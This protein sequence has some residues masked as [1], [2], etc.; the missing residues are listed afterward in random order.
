MKNLIGKAKALFNNKKDNFN[1]F[2]LDTLVLNERY[3]FEYEADAIEQS[4]KN[5]TVRLTGNPDYKLTEILKKAGISMSGKIINNCYSITEDFEE[6][7]QNLIEDIEKYNIFS[8]YLFKDREGNYTSNGQSRSVIVYIGYTNY[9]K[10]GFIVVHFHPW[11]QIGQNMSLMSN[12]SIYNKEEGAKEKI[13]RCL[14][15]FDLNKSDWI[16]EKIK[17]DRVTASKKVEKNKELDYYEALSLN[18]LNGPGKYKEKGE[19][20]L[21]NNR[22]RDAIEYLTFTHKYLSE[23]ILKNYNERLGEHFLIICDR[24]GECYYNRGL[25]KMA[26]YYWEQAVYMIENDAKDEIKKKLDSVYIKL[27]DIR[28]PDEQKEEI[29]PTVN[30]FGTVLKDIYNII[31]DELSF[32]LWIDN[33][34]NESELVNDINKIWNL[35]LCNIMNRHNDVSIY[36]SYNKLGY[37]IFEKEEKLTDITD[38]SILDQNRS[39]IINMKKKGGYV[40]VT[41]LMAPPMLLDNNKDNILKTLEIDFQ[42]R[43]E[44]DEEKLQLLRQ[45]AKDSVEKEKSCEYMEYFTLGNNKELNLLFINGAQAFQNKIWGDALFYLLRSLNILQRD[46]G[47]EKVDQFEYRMFGEVCY[48]LG[49][50]YMEFNIYSKA[51]YYLGILHGSEEVKYEIEFINALTNSN[52]VRTFGVLNNERQRVE[53]N[54]NMDD[55]EKNMYMSFLKRRYGYCLIEMEKIKEAVQY[56]MSMLTDEN[57]KDFAKEELEYLRRKYKK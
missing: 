57:C 28:K 54:N 29:R 2:D 39:V 32:M 27:N 8:D 14:L 7:K 18:L 36:L 12:I 16:L 49:F 51:I 25:Y 42:L 53:S 19:E 22:W 41:L 52:D 30:L 34:S 6:K 44:Y 38:N 4:E 24:L 3:V 35:D 33:E 15:V 46:W 13:S 47:T 48:M 1:P 45:K 26:S 21:K 5:F 10:K 43:P 11:G 37:R 56:F 55:D 9:E 23:Q 40:S 20:Y 31:E 17:A 50:V